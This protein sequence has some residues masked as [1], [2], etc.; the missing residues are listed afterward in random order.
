MLF[1]KIPWEDPLKLAKN[2]SL[3]QDYKDNWM[4]LSSGLFEEVGASKSY[5][6]LYPKTEIIS[7]NF[8]KLENEL[9]Q[10]NQ[11]FFGY[12]SYDLKNVL[13]S[14]PQDE[15]FKI[16][17][18][19]LWF[20]N[21]H[22]I[23]EFDHDQKI[24]NCFYTDKNFLHKIPAVS[25][26][27]ASAQIKISEIQSN[28]TK[29]EYLEKVV[30]I[31]NKIVE[32]DLYQAN[33]TRK[34]YGKIECDNKFD[35]FLKLNE[36][37]PANYSA[38]LKLNDNYIISSSPE[39]FLTID[40]NSKVKSSPIKGTTP[41]FAD[42]KQDILSKEFLQNSTKEQSENL[43]IVDLVRNDL[44]KGCEVNSVKVDNLF[45]INSYKTLHHMSSDISGIKNKGM[46]NLD[47]VKNCFPPASMTGTPKLKAIE[48]CSDL[49][50]VKRGVYS[51]AIGMISKSECNLSVVI[52][53]LI[54]QGDN[55]EFQV[56]GAIT[57]D[58]DP[59]KEWE[60]TINKAKGISSAINLPLEK[61]KKI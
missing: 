51:G 36:V 2:I 11:R 9:K 21:F 19:N 10:Q 44:S 29:A 48:I 30:K 42:S 41:R 40:K 3:S 56:G 59:I 58:S 54:V 60:E 55:F 26:L 14:L 35:I 25:D 8:D 13:E 22:L 27:K 17:L 31:K 1:R 45:K 47:I 12:F 61:L 43:M 49:E 28:F 52:R 53:T 7:E 4:F 16:N 37:S 24:I 38:F 5:L 23:L 50:K 46:S 32:G 20:I 39:L 18:P 33:L 6:A 34:F 15:N 57:H